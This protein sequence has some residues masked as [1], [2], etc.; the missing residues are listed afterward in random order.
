VRWL[1][2]GSL[3]RIEEWVESDA[4]C[5]I[6][7]KLLMM[8]FWY[9]EEHVGCIALPKAIFTSWPADK[10]LHWVGGPSQR[11]WSFSSARLA[12]RF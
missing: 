2:C 6:S 1:V 12:V 4:V 3:D 11:G 7:N 10:G 5:D 9:E 8:P